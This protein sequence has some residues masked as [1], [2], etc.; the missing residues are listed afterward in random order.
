MLPRIKRRRRKISSASEG[1]IQQN[2]KIL[3]K[4]KPLI[5]TDAQRKEHN[6]ATHCYLCS[7]PFHDDKVIDHSHLTGLFRGSAHRSCNLKLKYQGRSTD[8]CVN[9]KKTWQ[10]SRGY[11]IP[12]I[13]HNLQG[14]DGHLIIKGFKKRL[15]PN[16]EIKCIPNSMEKY[17]SFQIGNF[18]FLDSYQFLSDSL[19]KLVSNLS[20]VD[21]NYMS[22]FFSGDKLDLLLRKGVFP[23]NYWDGPARLEETQLPPRSAFYNQLVSQDVS[24]EDYTHAQTVFREFNLKTL[25][26]YH[27]LYLTT[28]ALLL[29]DVFENFRKISMR[30]DGLDPTHYLSAPGL[31]WDSMLKMTRIELE[32]LTDPLMHDMIDKG[33]RGGMCFVSGKYARANNKY[34][35]DF[36]PEKPSSYI[37]YLDCNNLYG[38]AMAQPMPERDFRFLTAHEISALDITSVSTVHQMV[39]FWR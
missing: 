5:I 3:S 10:E 31:T 33:I 8:K 28:D 34:L 29:A 14:Y 19:E 4:E 36:D 12:V 38:T 15:F 27:D 24:E 7:Q 6:I 2:R 39:I 13:F 18:K 26:E 17:L 32:L 23:Y 25:G 20:K 21:F 16:S 22:Y 35:E 11:I 9:S 1:G 30:I 37:M